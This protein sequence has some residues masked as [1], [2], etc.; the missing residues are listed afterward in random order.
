MEKMD[1]SAAYERDLLDWRATPFV[2]GLKI[3]AREDVA[4]SKSRAMAGCYKIEDAPAWPPDG[5]ESEC[6]CLCWWQCIFDDEQPEGGWRVP[7]RRHPKAGPHFPP[8]S[9][10]PM[11]RESMQALGDVLNSCGIHVDAAEAWR[12]HEIDQLPW[13]KRWWRRLLGA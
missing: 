10:A 6:G 3:T 8:P 2:I 7:V 4:C 5:C 1:H 11:T 12:A 13:W 9:P